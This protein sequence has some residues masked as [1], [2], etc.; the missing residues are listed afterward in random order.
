MSD[1]YELYHC[2]DAR[3]FRVLWT[4]E[5]LK[6]DYTLHKL[7]FPPRLHHKD[8]LEINPLGTVP[9]FL[10]N[11]KL[12]TES[13]AIVHYLVMKHHSTLHPDPNN[14]NF[15][16]YLDWLYRSDAT[17][18][19]PLTLVLRYSKFE[20]DEHKNEQV[21]NDYTRWFLS[22]V[23]SVERALE[24]QDYLINNQFSAAD[25]CIGYSLYL[26]KIMGLKDKFGSNTQAYLERLMQR[27]SF[28][29]ALVKQE[30]MN[31]YLA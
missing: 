1:T 31:F 17:L 11:K 19:F 14:E 23:K 15:P 5:E 4:L 3:S 13:S 18:T 30:D 7:S 25:I 10:V 20:A 12:M 28:K 29:S 24:N 8:F 6:I 9:A 26:A 2:R 16:V 27:Q 22:R 21:S